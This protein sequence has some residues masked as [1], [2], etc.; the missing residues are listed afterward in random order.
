MQEYDSGAGEWPA[1]ERLPTSVRQRASEIEGCALSIA[2]L[3][4]VGLDDWESDPSS[5]STAWN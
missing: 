2:L 4:D 5:T 1:E 3:L